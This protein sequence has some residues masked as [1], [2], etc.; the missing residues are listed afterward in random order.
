MKTFRSE[1]SFVVASV[2][3]LLP[4]R[5]K[6]NL[7]KVS[8]T[9]S[10]KKFCPKFSLSKVSPKFSLKKVYPKFSLSKVSPKFSLK[11]ICPK[12]SL[13]KVSPKF[14]L[15]KVCPKF[16]LSKVSPNLRCFIQSTFHPSIIYPPPFTDILLSVILFV[17]RVPITP[18][19]PI[20]PT[21]FPQF[22]PSF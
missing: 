13:S 17:L 7:S 18:A 2:D 6:F 19:F 22:H 3:P 1:A 4:F 5:P 21:L 14:S 15:K 20:F 8:P 16:R 9:F 11:K 10:L 12:F